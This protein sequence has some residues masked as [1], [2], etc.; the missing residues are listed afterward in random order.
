MIGIGAA[1]NTPHTLGTSQAL[2]CRSRV[3][4][5]ALWLVLIVVVVV[6]GLLAMTSKW[7][8][9]TSIVVRDVVLRVAVAVLKVCVLLLL[10]LL[11]LSKVDGV[12]V[13]WV[14]VV[15]VSG[16]VACKAWCCGCR[17]AVH[18]AVAAVE[19]DVDEVGCVRV[20]AA[21]WVLV[22]VSSCVGVLRLL[23][24]DLAAMGGIV[25]VVLGHAWLVVI[26]ESGV[27]IRGCCCCGRCDVAVETLTTATAKH[28]P[29]E[30]CE[31]SSNH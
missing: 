24:L 23:A 14:L 16:A 4:D 19:R 21:C 5:A 13:L 10:L 15:G 30:S 9:W 25:A 22:V 31:E 1:R 2:R 11:L 12:G 27:L 7:L 28:V 6:A 17:H 3:R 18:A 26:F 8:V 20:V 29:C